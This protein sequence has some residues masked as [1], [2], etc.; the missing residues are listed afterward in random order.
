M[1]W[2]RASK[3]RLRDVDAAWIFAIT[4]QHKA[5]AETVHA[6]GELLFVAPEDARSHAD[7]CRYERLHPTSLQGP[8]LHRMFNDK[9]EYQQDYTGLQKLIGDGKMNESA[10]RIVKKREWKAFLDPLQETCFGQVATMWV[11]MLGS[12]SVE[13]GVFMENGFELSMR[14]PKAV[15]QFYDD[16]LKKQEQWHVSA[17]GRQTSGDEL[18]S[19][20]PTTPVVKPAINQAK[21]SA[22]PP[23]VASKPANA[24]SPVDGA[25]NG[26]VN[27]QA[28]LSAPETS[29]E[30]LFAKLKAGLDD[31][32]GVEVN[33]LADDVDVADIGIDS[34]IS[35][36]LVKEIQRPSTTPSTRMN[37]DDDGYKSA[38]E[39]ET[40]P[41]STKDGAIG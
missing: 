29:P 24:H 41:T 22:P 20:T 37:S 33:K 2:F 5:A 36:E 40:P 35:M 39:P 6:T 27:G 21:S 14:S 31:I 16:D 9:V 3:N 18:T 10:G 13:T 23:E 1:R 32:A 12:S 4:S 25:A 26:P 28:P 19:S 17:G 7:F 11:N 30:E 8:S 38:P 15:K 34:M